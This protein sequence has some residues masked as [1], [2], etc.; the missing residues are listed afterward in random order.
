MDRSN[1]NVCVALAADETY[2]PALAVAVRSVIDNFGDRRRLT[3]Y[4]LDRGLTRS[5]KRKLRSSWP[6]R[7]NVRFVRADQVLLESLP[8]PWDRAIIPHVNQSMYIRLF[9]PD[10]LPHDESRVLY[11][12]ADTLALAD[13]TD[14]W[15]VDLKGYPVAAVQD[16]VLRVV[17]SPLVPLD[18]EELGLGP[19]AKY[20]NSGVLLMDLDVWR[21]EDLSERV[22]RYLMENQAEVRFPDQDALN[23]VLC[24]R[25]K[26]L[27]ISWNVQVNEWIR[28][29]RIREGRHAEAWLPNEPNRVRE[30][31]PPNGAKIMHFVGR[32]KPWT[33]RFRHEAYRELYRQYQRRTAWPSGISAAPR[34]AKEHSGREEV[35]TRH[36]VYLSRGHGFGHASIDLQII[37]SIR[38]ARPDIKITVASSGTGLEYYRWQSSVPCIDLGIPDD[39]DQSHDAARRVLW[40]L[41]NV[42]RP[43]LVVAHEV[44]AAPIVC[45]KLRLDNLLVTDWFF[46]EIGTPQ[47]DQVFRNANGVILLDFAAGHRIPPQ[48]GAPVHVMGPVVKEFTMSREQARKELGLTEDCFVAVATFGSIR[49]DKLPDIRK[50]LRTVLDAWQANAGNND[51]LLVLADANDELASRSG[52]G[53]GSIR[54]AGLTQT[55]EVF[56][57]AAD[58]VLAYATGAT[59]WE[60]MRNG[61]PAIGIIGSINPVDR[62]RAEYL[63]S[64]GYIQAAELNTKPDQLWHLVKRSMELRVSSRKATSYL[65]WGEPEGVAKLILS[66]LPS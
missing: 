54:W 4:V 2:A 15:D 37:E 63:A 3:I 57:C 33:S 36:I 5:T 58:V 65:E 9:I 48:L 13:V 61:I 23:A 11:L 25:W 49:Q 46:S 40:F 34:A 35:D 51:K 52:P 38:T 8:M 20:F 64:A 62:V 30:S 44:F 53:E 16:A 60:M 21:T 22:L 31:V 55:P 41:D 27:D 66:Y 28:M 10:L 42:G 1:S 12:D 50:I 24:D 7:A 56:Y 45:A 18:H 14:L 6:E 32:H 26:Q 39:Y 47:G 17:S 19:N 29:V 43:G 59:L